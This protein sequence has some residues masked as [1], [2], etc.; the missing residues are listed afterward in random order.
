MAT[1]EPKQQKHH[2]TAKYFKTDRYDNIVFLV[3]TDADF[4]SGYSK[5]VKYH[6]RLVSEF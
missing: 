6:Q 3:S 5:V 1:K 2:I 4:R